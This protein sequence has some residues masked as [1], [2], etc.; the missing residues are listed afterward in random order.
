MRIVET[1]RYKEAKSGPDYN[2]QPNMNGQ[3]GCVPKQLFGPGPENEDSIVKNWR[4][5]RK[6]KKDIEEE[7]MPEGML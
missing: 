1:E 5:K 7:K 6:K 4:K 2:T 3:P